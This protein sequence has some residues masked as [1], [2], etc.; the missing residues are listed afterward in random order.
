MRWL[1]HTLL[2]A[3]LAAAAAS[4]AKPLAPPDERFAEFLAKQQSSAPIKLTEESYRA[5]TATP[6]N[7]SVAV[8]LTALEPRLGCRMCTDFQPE[9]DVLTRSWSRA[10]RLG[11]SRVLF[12]TLDF[13]EGRDVFMS[14]CGSWPLPQPSSTFWGAKC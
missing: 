12:G 14:V 11:E 2:M 7:Y 1:L 10:D 4:A 6:R 3:A 13:E 5:V 8:L 9:W